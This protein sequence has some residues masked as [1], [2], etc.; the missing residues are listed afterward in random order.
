ML[1][2]IQPLPLPQVYILYSLFFII[3]I[4]EKDNNKMT[5]DNR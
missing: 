5:I 2:L 3:L 4:I 1:I